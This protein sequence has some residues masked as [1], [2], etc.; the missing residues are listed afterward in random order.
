LSIVEHFIGSLSNFVHE[1]SSGEAKKC[2][3]GH[4]HEG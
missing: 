4:R 1:A 2:G 3:D